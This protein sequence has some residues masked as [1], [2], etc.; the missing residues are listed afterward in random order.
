[1]G[2]ASWTAIDEVDLNADV[3]EPV[4]AGGDGS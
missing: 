4:R 3:A 2:Q 1:M